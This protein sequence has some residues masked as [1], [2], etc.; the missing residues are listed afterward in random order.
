MI[1][2]TINKEHNI[3]TNEKLITMKRGEWYLTAP[4]Q[5]QP[6][7]NP[8]NISRHSSLIHC[9]NRY[10]LDKPT[11]AFPVDYLD[12]ARVNTAKPAW[13]CACC[14]KRPPSSILTVFILQNYDWCS[15]EVS[16]GFGVDT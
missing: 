6:R 11:M 8:N 5:L 15:E 3:V 10:A 1:F 16:R 9:C 14:Y 4:T 2:N 12:H 7:Y 13:R